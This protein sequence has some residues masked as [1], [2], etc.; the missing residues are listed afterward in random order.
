MVEDAERKGLITP[1][2]SVLIEPTS[3]NTGTVEGHSEWR[4]KFLVFFILDIVGIWVWFW[5]G[6]Q[7]C[8]IERRLLIIQ[9]F[10]MI[11][12]T[13]FLPHP[14]H[15]AGAVWSR[16]G[17][18]LYHCN[19]WEDEQWEGGRPEGPWCWNCAHTHQCSLGLPR[20]PHLCG[21]EAGE[22][23]SRCNNPGSG[24]RRMHVVTQI[25]SV[26]SGHGYRIL[27]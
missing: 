7:F 4:S 12:T 22:G 26:G 9:H 21:K 11:I 10:I 23:D 24:T 17:L 6:Q 27:L 3:G 13:Y 20:I 18:P 8:V 2:V 19:A 16:E 14:R 25:L 1:G 15:W 5:Y